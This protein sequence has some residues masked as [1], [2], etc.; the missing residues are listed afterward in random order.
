MSN[1]PQRHHYIPQFILKNFSNEQN[2][3]LYWDVRKKTL[4]SRNPKSVFM[5]FHMYR[6]EKN[7]PDDPTI[8]EKMF[9]AFEGEIANLLRDKFIEQDEIVITR[10]EL[11]KLRIFMGLLSFRSDLRMNQY[12]QKNFD[13]RTEEILSLYEPNQNFEDLWKRE[14]F[15]LTKCRSIK[16]VEDNNEIDEIIKTDFLNLVQGFYLTIVDAR[17]G[18]FILSDIYPT[19]EVF[20]LMP[21]VN[22]HLHE[23]YPISST[24]MI[25]LNHIMFKKGANHNNPIINSMVKRS[26]IGENMIKEPKSKRVNSFNVFSPEDIFIYKPVKIYENDLIYINELILNE[27]RNGIMFKNKERIFKSVKCFN[28]RGDTKQKHNELEKALQ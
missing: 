7:H 20:N 27:A 9:S 23:L 6:D 22:I 24:R 12:K 28:E 5:N 25:L 3:L 13:S 17:G 2:Q 16:D 19:L 10:A 4:S 18:E 14:L 21:N 11:E 15:V 26:K 1:E 8:I